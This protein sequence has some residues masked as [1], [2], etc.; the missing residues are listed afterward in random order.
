M[1]ATFPCCFKLAKVSES[2][3]ILGAVVAEAAAAAAA[4]EARGIMRSRRCWLD[5]LCE[6]EE[7][8]QNCDGK[9]FNEVLRA[10]GF[11]VS[12]ASCSPETANVASALLPL[13]SAIAIPPNACAML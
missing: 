6:E 12:A 7:E 5:D 13:A 11:D 10:A 1:S 4:A 8:A 3:V 9:R 2:R